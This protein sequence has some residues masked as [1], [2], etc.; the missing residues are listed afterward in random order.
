MPRY[1]KGRTGAWLE[2]SVRY[3]Q[4]VRI[5]LFGKD[6]H[7]P[8]RTTKGVAEVDRSEIR[9]C[10][11]AVDQ[12]AMLVRLKREAGGGRLRTGRGR[13]SSGRGR[14]AESAQ[15]PKQ[16]GPPC[17]GV[18]GPAVILGVA[19]MCQEAAE[20]K[21]EGPISRCA[22]HPDVRCGETASALDL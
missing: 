12:K 18:T 13:M 4:G 5:K 19:A 6:Y 20:G 7:G 2:I 1:T 3:G 22:T 15:G 17:L 16:Q 10:R 21:K 9:S 14:G 8:W 11:D